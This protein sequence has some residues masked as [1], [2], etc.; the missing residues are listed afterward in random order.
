MPDGGFLA[1]TVFVAVGSLF[2]IAGVALLG[3]RTPSS[4]PVGGNSL[5]NPRQPQTSPNSKAKSRDRREEKTKDELVQ[6]IVQAGFYRKSTIVN[7]Q[8]IRIA[9]PV[10]PVILGISFWGLGIITPVTAAILAVASGALGTV[11]P[12][13]WLDYKRNSRQQALSQS[14]PDALDVII[15]CVEAGLSLP[16]SMARVARELAGVHPLLASE[17]A[18][19]QREIQMGCSTGESLQRLAK[20]FDSDEVRG[21]ASVITQAEKYGASIMN[22]LRVHAESMRVKRFQR[23]EERASKAAVKLVFPTILCI[24]PALFIVLAGPAVFRIFGMFEQMGI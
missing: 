24:F 23:A 20:R 4:A 13:F 1:I 5:A 10:L 2:L 7:F 3:R 15:I 18:I 16:A 12:S 22:A 8:A 11:I 17:L 21:L 19:C 9:L 6:R 14:L